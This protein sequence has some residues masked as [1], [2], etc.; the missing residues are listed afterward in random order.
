MATN[1]LSMCGEGF[2]YTLSLLLGTCAFLMG[3]A[4]LNLGFKP[5]TRTTLESSRNNTET[6]VPSTEPSV[7]EVTQSQITHHASTSSHSV[8]QDI[9]LRDQ[10]IE[11]VN[12]IGEPSEGM[13]TRS[14]AAKL[15][16][17]STS[18]CLFANFLFEIEHTN[19]FEA[20]KHP[21]W[22][23][24]MQE[25]L[26]Q[27]YRNNFYTLFPLPYGKIAIGSKWVF[28][29]KNDE[30]RTVVKNKARLVAQGFS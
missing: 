22:E 11:L 25:E 26:N 30:L 10:H 20:L 15:T 3:R 13:L 2:F 9:W 1:T 14:M 8:P 6:S 16:T 24:A 7:L 17:A 4:W 29:N 21:G 19:V 27:F 5:E 12:I 18:E 23:D 28:R